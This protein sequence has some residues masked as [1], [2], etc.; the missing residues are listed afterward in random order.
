MVVALLAGAAAEAQAKRPRGKKAAAE[1]DAQPAREPKVSLTP[2]PRSAPSDKAS[3]AKLAAKAWSRVTGALLPE[4]LTRH[5][6]RAL[7]R[8]WPGISEH[9]LG[10]FGS[11]ATLRWRDTLTRALTELEPLEAL[12]LPRMARAQ[13][14]ALADR[15]EAELLLLGGRTPS[16]SDPV[17]YVQR[18]FRALQAA[19]EAEWMPPERR[20]ATLALLLQELP[21]YFRDARVSLVDP[22]AQW[23][24]LALLDLDDLQELLLEIEAS[25]PEDSVARAPKTG[26]APSPAPGSAPRAALDGFRSW[27]LELRPSAGGRPPCLDA[28]E[29]QRLARLWSGTTWSASEIKTHCLRELA[30]LDLSARMERPG[31]PRASDAPDLA[32]QA[33]SASARALQ[34]G[35]EAH[36]LRARLE[37]QAVEFALE[38]SPRMRPE[39]AW[40]RP[41]GPD[42][43]RVY[44]ALPHGSWPPGEAITRKRSL[45]DARAA[46]GVRYGMVGEALYALQNRACR[47]APALL[48]DNRLLQE[49]FGLFALDW[50][51]RVDWIENP[52]HTGEEKT[53]EEQE[54]AFDSQR[55]LEAAR[56]LAAIELHVE[57]LS[58]EESAQGF[59]RRTGIDRDTARVEALAAQRDPLHGLGYLGLIELRG[60]EQRLARLTKPREGLRLCLL[61]A[62]RHPDLRPVDMASLAREGTPPARS[63]KE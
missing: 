10:T 19:A 49:G 21:A 13:L 38:V 59:Q 9:P 16:T 62:L 36:L 5:P 40:L 51:S 3:Q 6:D 54:L 46:L 2:T 24:D 20:Q 14:A 47:S 17:G 50:V 22:A 23:I 58:L 33:W 53:H 57:G 7:E 60:L 18:A 4:F 26:R 45:Q 8:A 15:L 35:V 61:L 56:L 48:L 43:M 55:G 27:L 37:P 12:D 11:A 63:R 28:K 34:L 32:Q 31:N 25:L 52:F 42:S 29:W 41:S 30:R 44:L 1:K 39:L